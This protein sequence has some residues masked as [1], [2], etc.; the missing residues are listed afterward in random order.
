MVPVRARVA[1]GAG[2]RVRVAFT[3]WAALLDQ[4][5]VQVDEELPKI[6][7]N[8]ICLCFMIPAYRPQDYPS[9]GRFQFLYHLQ[10]WARG[11]APRSR[12]IGKNGVYLT[13]IVACVLGSV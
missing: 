8:T 6:A 5:F 3:I 2:D 12:S 1:V 10:F 4:L 11:T 7:R 13:L 9:G